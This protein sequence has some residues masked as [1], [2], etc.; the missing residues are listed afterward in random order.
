[1]EREARRLFRKLVSGQAWLAPL[2]AEFFTFATEGRLKRPKV[3][4]RLVAAFVK[5]DWLRRREAEPE[6]FAL[7]EAGEGW[8]IR[9]QSIEAPFAAQHQLRR[10]ARIETEEGAR[11]VTV[12]D[13]ES[14]LGWLKKRGL[15]DEVQ[16]DAG[17]RLRRDFTIAQLT[18]RMGVDWS[19]PVVL[20]SRG[21]K[22]DS[23]LP[24]VV[25]DAKQR[26]ARALKSVGPGLSDLL[27]DV[28]CHLMGLEAAERTKGWPQRS[29][30]VVLQIALDQLATHYGMRAAGPVRAKT[31]VWREEVE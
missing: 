8:L 30:K 9:T 14:P 4:A 5:R 1:V 19:A 3:E 18:P 27:F 26:F 12:N 20:G 17:E 29:A 25:L 24:E 11:S 2:D 21:A 23:A 7:S 31:R 10:E 28:C 16:F 15:I 6:T 22:S 13:G